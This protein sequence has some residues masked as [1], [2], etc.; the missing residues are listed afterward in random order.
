MRRAK[1][2]ALTAAAASSRAALER[3]ACEVPLKTA[4]SPGIWDSDETSGLLHYNLQRCT[5]RRF[6]GETTKRCLK[7]KHVVLLGQSW[8][9]YLYMSL[10]YLLELGQFPKTAANHSICWEGSWQWPEGAPEPS[11]MRAAQASRAHV[12]GT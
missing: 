9:R 12:R 3:P 8:T 7:G 6:D 11:W 1:I 4:G 5:L 2:L 10:V